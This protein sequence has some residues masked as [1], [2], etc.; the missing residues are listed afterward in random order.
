MAWLQLTVF[1]DASLV[2]SISDAMHH[3][4]AEAVTM[5]DAA[6]EELFEPL[7]GE[8]PL[9]SFTEVTGLFDEAKQASALIDALTAR[10]RLKETLRYESQIIDDQDWERAWLADFRPMQF[11]KKLWIVPTVYEVVDPDA[12]NI[13]LDPGLAFGTGTHETTALCLEWLDEHPIQNLDVIDYGCGSG[14]LAIAAAMLGAKHIWGVDIDPQAVTATYSNAEMNAVA[15]KIEAGLP[16]TFDLPQVDVLL[17]NILANP[18]QVLAVEFARLVKSGGHIVLS[19]LLAEQKEAVL[20][21]YQDWFDMDEAVQRGD[22]VMLS[23]RRKDNPV[24]A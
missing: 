11:G 12:V 16:K 10:L 2:D 8:V 22:W 18:L 5:K 21:A 23:G 17:A 1:A 15:D 19:G 4:G 20:Q 24:S 7:P 3:L 13:R 9:W 6:G 14:I